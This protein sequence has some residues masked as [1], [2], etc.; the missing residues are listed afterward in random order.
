MICMKHG[1]GLLRAAT[2]GQAAALIIP[3]MNSRRLMPALP[4][5][6]NVA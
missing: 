4:F 6:G 3:A 1:L 5:T 2:T